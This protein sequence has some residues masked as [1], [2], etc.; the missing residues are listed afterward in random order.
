M[1]QSKLIMS[2]RINNIEDLG[3]EFYSYL[4]KLIRSIK[5]NKESNNKSKNK[6]NWNKKPKSKNKN[7][8]MKHESENKNRKKIEKKEID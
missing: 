4:L 2:N 3:L 7:N 1:N 8:K 5:N 6:K